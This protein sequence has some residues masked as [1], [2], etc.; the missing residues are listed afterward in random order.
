VK[1]RI[2]MKKLQKADRTVKQLTTITA[3]R[4]SPKFTN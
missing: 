4:N 1:R 2:K 3:T